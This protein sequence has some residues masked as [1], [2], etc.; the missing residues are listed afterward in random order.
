MALKTVNKTPTQRE[1]GILERKHRKLQEKYDSIKYQFL[2]AITAEDFEV[3]SVNAFLELKEL[4][5]EKKK[6]Y[7]KTY[8][9]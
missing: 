3:L 2:E 9:H 8:R 4:Y 6:L 5:I 7:W 1:I